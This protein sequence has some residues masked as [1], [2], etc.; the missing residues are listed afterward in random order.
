M[1]KLLLLTVCVGALVFGG[2]T[3]STIVSPHE[4]TLAANPDFEEKE[5]V[6]IEWQ[7][8]S[9]DAKE[10]FLDKEEYPYSRD[11]VILLEPTEK[12]LQLLWVVADDFPAEELDHYAEDLVKEF[13]NIVASQDFTIER[14]GVDSYGGLWKE[15]GLSV[16]IIPESTKEDPET[17][18]MDV[19]Y[20]AGTDFE[21]PHTSEALAYMKR[22][23]D[24]GAD[25]E[26]E[27][28]EETE[29]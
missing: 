8:V 11:L 15:Y 12:Q 22:N 5:N 9:D 20:E 16:G 29:E 13:N 14:S 19:T 1:K 25:A 28:S 21:L 17:W 27:G 3:K 23:P 6:E 24:G 10:L 2:C 26:E 4:Y 7:Q 18:F